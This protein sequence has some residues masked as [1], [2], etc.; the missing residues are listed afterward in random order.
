MKLKLE[1]NSVWKKGEDHVVAAFD[2]PKHTRI[3]AIV[4]RYFYAS[5][6]E[7]TVFSVEEFYNDG[8]GDWVSQENPYC[9]KETTRS[10]EAWCFKDD[11]LK[12]TKVSILTGDK[13][14]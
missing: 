12:E 7:D 1:E 14:V 10:F 4:Q 5:N 6:E 3:L 2:V 9:A 11:L 8:H 13:V